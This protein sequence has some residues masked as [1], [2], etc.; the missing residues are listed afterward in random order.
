M[1]TYFTAKESAAVIVGDEHTMSPHIEEMMRRMG[2]PVPD[3]ESVL[4]LNPDHLWFNRYR[5]YMQQM[6]KILKQALT[7][8]L[9]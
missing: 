1:E 8:I 6:Q 7:R 9:P 5:N 4:E 3:H 2:Q